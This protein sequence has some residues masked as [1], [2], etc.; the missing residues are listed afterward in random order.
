MLL[1]HTILSSDFV[2]Q[3]ILH[4]LKSALI[5]KKALLAFV[6]YHSDSQTS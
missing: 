6:Q 3:L 4:I 1:P 5:T 2:T